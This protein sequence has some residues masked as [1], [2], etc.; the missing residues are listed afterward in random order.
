M[1]NDSDRHG[2]TVRWGVAAVCLLVAAAGGFLI[3]SGN[4]ANTGARRPQA[5]DTGHARP[6]PAPAARGGVSP[7]ATGPTN[8]RCRTAPPDNITPTA[9]PSDLTWRN[10][11]TV[12]VPV[13]AADGPARH[14][15]A[16]WSCYAHSP[17]G[18]VLAS[19]GIPATLT[20]PGWLTARSPWS[21]S[22][23]RPGGWRSGAAANR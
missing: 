21:A 7:S 18:A 22:W 16:A 5:D 2:R 20:G 3:F 13:S 19:Y 12:L 15:G 6:S 1:S 8:S 23:R 11:G 17:M 10:V 9:P 14:T 4:G